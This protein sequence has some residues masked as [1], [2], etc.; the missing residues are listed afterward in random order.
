MQSGPGGIWG[1]VMARGEGQ[2][3]FQAGPGEETLRQRG[4]AAIGEIEFHALDAVHREKD[5][6]GSGHLAVADHDGEVL[7]RGELDSADART[8][9]REGQD[10]SPEPFARIGQRG[11]H[12]C[13]G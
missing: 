12:R 5:D 10:H 13:A 1:G 3:R 11:N 7:V 4:Q 9:G 6:G 8:R 2:R